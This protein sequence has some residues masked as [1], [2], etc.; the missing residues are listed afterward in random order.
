[1]MCPICDRDV[2]KMT[3]HHLKPT[4]KVVNIVKGIV[5]LKKSGKIP[6]CETC[7]REIHRRFSNEELRN[8]FNTIERLRDALG[9]W[10]S[11][12]IRYK[13]DTHHVWRVEGLQGGA[14]W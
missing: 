9:I 12:N 6:M 7:Q 3:K 11:K 8:E 2:E 10:R 13:A 4:V 5:T 14:I 1:M